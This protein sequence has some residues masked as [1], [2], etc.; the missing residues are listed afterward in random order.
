MERFYNYMGGTNISLDGL[1]SIWGS[2]NV[3][4]ASYPMV[5]WFKEIE[6]FETLI[7]DESKV[8]IPYGG[9]EKHGIFKRIEWNRIKIK[10]Y[11]MCTE[12]TEDW[13]FFEPHLVVE[14][15]GVEWF[16]Y[17]Y[18]AYEE[19]QEVIHI[20]KI[21][22]QTVELFSSKGRSLGF[23]NEYEFNDI[24]IQIKRNKIEGY[25]IMFSDEKVV[26]NSDGGIDNWVDGLFD[27]NTK[28]L[29]ILFDI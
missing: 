13:W 6:V 25:Y 8:F 3:D 1:V 28:Q 5:E 4:G 2:L 12:Q 21:I 19:N 24:R 26:I 29:N 14:L 17:E 7:P 10:N 15:D 20:N 22:P 23:I 9:C 27:L 18:S 16:V 11:S